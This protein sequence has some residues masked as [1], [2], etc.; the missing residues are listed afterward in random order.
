M[1]WK[2][3]VSIVFYSALF[4]PDV[5]TGHSRPTAGDASLAYV[6]VIPHDGAPYFN[7][8]DG[9]DIGAL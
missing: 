9:R 4:R 5:I 3:A 2:T 8:R 7:N 1:C 6:P